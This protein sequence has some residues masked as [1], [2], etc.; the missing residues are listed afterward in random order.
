ML[1]TPMYSSYSF[2]KLYIILYYVLLNLVQYTQTT[3][4]TY[5]SV[6]DLVDISGNKFTAKAFQLL[7]VLMQKLLCTCTCIYTY[8]KSNI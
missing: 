2:I 1:L 4:Y 6:P 7:P 8:R 3:L 5:M